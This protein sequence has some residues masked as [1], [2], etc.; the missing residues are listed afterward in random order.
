MSKLPPL[1]LNQ[2][3][4]AANKNPPRE[5]RRRRMASQ[6]S[7][8]SNETDRRITSPASGNLNEA[9]DENEQP[10]RFEFNFNHPFF[11]IY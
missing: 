9:F 4:S 1:N 6:L 10:V 2:Q 5:R 8:G 3:S 11:N 7:N